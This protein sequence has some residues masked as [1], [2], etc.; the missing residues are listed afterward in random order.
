VVLVITV[1]CA[2]LG[3]TTHTCATFYATSFFVIR[4]GCAGHQPAGSHRTRKH[5]S[6][7]R[8][9]FGGEIV[10]CVLEPWERWS[11][12]GVHFFTQQPSIAVPRQSDSPDDD[13]VCVAQECF[14][15]LSVTVV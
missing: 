6:S 15:R 3:D 4:I 14:G 8:A 7:S 13:M 5:R 2:I 12:S 9:R 11:F 1:R 10:Q